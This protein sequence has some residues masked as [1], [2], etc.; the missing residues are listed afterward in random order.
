MLLTYIL[1]LKK[2]QDDF[3]QKWDTDEYERLAAERLRELEEGP[4]KKS[5]EPPVKRSLLKARDFTV[6]QNQ[7]ER[8][9][10]LLSMTKASVVF[11][12]ERL[13]FSC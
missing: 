2:A 4:S 12:S 10:W 3:R 13:M 5:D 11:V 1:Y 9:E 7:C 8:K 6:S